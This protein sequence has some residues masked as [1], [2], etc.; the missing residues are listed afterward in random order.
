MSR[1]T[2]QGTCNL[3]GKTFAKAAMTRHL[4]K[5]QPTQHD[6]A[7]K[8]SRTQPKRTLHLRVEGAWLAYYWMHIEIAADETLDTLD[9]F[10]RD[11]WLECC[12]HLSAFTI[13]GRRYAI[14][15]VDDFMMDSDFYEDSMGYALGE[16]LKPGTKFTYEYD[17]GTTTNL[18]LMVV[19]ERQGAVKRKTVEIL[20]RNNP[21][22]IKCEKCKKELATQVCGVCIYNEPAW[23]CDNCYTNH[24]CYKKSENYFLPVVN[25]PRVGMCGYT[26]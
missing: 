7:S 13:A 1:Q 5:C 19:S 3:C 12:G 21:P 2:S 11:I 8:A 15:P 17:Y 6:K 26:G 10:L 16:V 9:Q 14:H 23:Y 20:A 24:K 22:E 25:S 4:A 18:A